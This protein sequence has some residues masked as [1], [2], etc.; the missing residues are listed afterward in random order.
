MPK[1]NTPQPKDGQARLLTGVR[2]STPPAARHLDLHNVGCRTQMSISI[3]QHVMRLT[4]EVT[5]RRGTASSVISKGPG[6]I[7]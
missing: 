6:R 7:A 2:A 1:L 5:D 4:N 3:A